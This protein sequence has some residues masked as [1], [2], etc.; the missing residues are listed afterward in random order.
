[1]YSNIH[2]TAGTLIVLGTYALTNDTVTSLALGGTLAFLSHDPLDRLGEKPYGDLKATLAW[3]V[4]PLAIFAYMAYLS[5]LWP[6]YAVGWVAGMGMDLVDKPAHLLWNK[7]PYFK[8][9]RRAPD[10]NFTLAQT[11]LATI[12]ATLVIV[13]VTL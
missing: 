2:G 8:C 6:L 7:G 11:K 12:L 5:G 13:G 10:I 9:H 4:V 1:M 3:E